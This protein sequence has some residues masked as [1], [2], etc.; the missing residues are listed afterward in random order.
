[1]KA[2]FTILAFYILAPVLLPAQKVI[3]IKIEGAINP[4]TADFIKESIQKASRENASCLLI[5]LNTPGGLVQSTRLIVADM[6]GSPVPIIVYV[7]PE[8]AQAGS[9]GVFI[10]MAANISAMTETSNIGAAHPV[11]LQGGMDSVMSE[12]VTNDA[13]A[14]I[15]SIA[16]KRN[17]NIEWAEE[18]V[19]KSVSTPASE[20]LEKH[21]IDLIASSDRELLEKVDGKQIGLNKGNVI[22][23]SKNATVEEYQ[24]GVLDKLLNI[25]SDPNIA[26]MMMMVGFFGIMF[27]F[28]NPGSILPGIIG[29]IALVF[30]F[31]AMHSLPVNYA[32]LALI[33]FGFVLLLL[34]IKVVSHGMLAIGGV[35]SLL[36]GSMMLIKAGSPFNIAPISYPLILAT[37]FVTALFFLLVLAAGIK[38]QKRAPVTGL[39]A[40]AGITGIVTESLMPHGRVRVNGELWKA[41]SL[42]GTVNKGETVRIKHIKNL[43]LFVEKVT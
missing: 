26:Y 27:E 37:T 13:A 42:S 32:G 24:M 2:L 17:R 22:I 3:S 30:A 29:V 38:A 10:T 21:V 19:R 41:D 39:E 23:H 7:A 25:I 1:M 20:A 6:L 43:V 36:L 11:N 40:M 31:Y 34:E 28:Y 8:G 14:F 35:V 15:R 16:A 12:K 33:I 4:V 5:H 18:A 9:A